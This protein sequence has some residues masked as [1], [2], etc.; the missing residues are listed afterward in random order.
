[1]QHVAAGTLC[2]L[3]NSAD[4]RVKL[5][6]AGAIPPLVALLDAHQ[7]TTAIQD[8][9]ARA[10]HNLAISPDNQV[11]IAAAGA[12][13]LLCAL[14]GGKGKSAVQLAAAGALRNLA[15]NTDN[16]ITITAAG[17][18]TPLVALLGPRSSAATQEYAAEALWSLASNDDILVEVTAAGAI[19]PLVALLGAPRPAAV[20]LMAAGALNCLARPMCRSKQRGFCR[21]CPTTPIIGSESPVPVS[22]PLRPCR[23]V[24]RARRR[25]SGK[26]G[27][28]SRHQPQYPCQDFRRRCHPP[29]SGAVGCTQHCTNPG[30]GCWGSV[31]PLRQL[32]QQ[33]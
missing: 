25:C 15:C 32:R 8:F 10:L 17:G 30:G 18:I 31:V 33:D 11:K 20:Q 22:S 13:P 6:A 2:A 3:A 23:P 14:L 7:S 24:L 28:T 1:M 27:I 4:N 19:A 16:R 5:A 12:I 21:T 26:Q 29:S 9:A